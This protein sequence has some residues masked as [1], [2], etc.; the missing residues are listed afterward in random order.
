M[1]IYH[2]VAAIVFASMFAPGIDT[3]AA[4]TPPAN[5]SAKAA[6]PDGLGSPRL[7]DGRADPR[8]Q[9]FGGG[10]GRQ[11]S[12]ATAGPGASWSSRRRPVPGNPWSWRDL[13]RNHQ[14]PAETELLARGFHLA[15][16]TPGPPRQRE[17]WLAFLTEKHRLARKPVFVGMSTAGELRAGTAKV[18][19]TPDDVKMPVHD[20][21]LRPQPGARRR[22]RADRHRRRGPGHL[23]QR[24]PG[25]GLQ[26]AVRDLAPRAQLLPHPLGPGP[27]IMP[28]SSRSGSSRSSKPR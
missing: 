11:G 12:A 9:T 22:R 15:F 26:G 16:I 20:K 14:P 13:H 17:A 10:D 5:E 18:S 3:R 21:C 24:A 6:W 25:R 23:H 2:G 7:R 27:Q 8:H 19:I 4:D 28:P 1:Y